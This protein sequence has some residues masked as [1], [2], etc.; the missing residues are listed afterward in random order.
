MDTHYNL[1]RNS[2]TSKINVI[3]RPSHELNFLN[4]NINKTIL[5]NNNITN[6]IFNKYLYKIKEVNKNKNETLYE[7][8]RLP[9]K[10][11]NESLFTK[12]KRIANMKYPAKNIND[13][14]FR[15]RQKKYFFNKN[16]KRC[17]SHDRMGV[18]PTPYCPGN[19]L[20]NKEKEE[21][22]DYQD[23][24]TFFDRINREFEDI[25]NMVNLFFLVG[26]KKYNVSKNEFV[27]L[28]LIQNELEEKYGFKIK[29]FIYKNNVLNVY[30]SLKDNNC[31]N[32]C[33]I[34]VVFQ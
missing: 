7:T 12:D 33:C 31:T 32:N 13:N 2:F 27:I 21:E 20:L 11:N 14:F 34:Q 19:N 17:A 22:N 4:S 23:I 15:F 5:N 18:L 6:N 3:N 8:S 1:K 16:R 9:F 25:G 28:K 29:E 10:L 24:N 26:N 30:K